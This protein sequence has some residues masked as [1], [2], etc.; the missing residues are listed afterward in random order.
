VIVRD[1]G[2]GI[3][4][5]HLARIF[6]PYFTTKQSGSG[7]G[8][9]TAYAVIQKHGGHIG[10]VSELGHGAIFTLYLPASAT[11]PQAAMAPPAAASAPAARRA[12]VLVMDDEPS[13]CAIVARM[14]KSSGC[15]VVAAADGDEAIAQYQ[16]A[17]AAGTP[18]DVVIMDL[19]IPGG[20][21]GEDAVKQLL[22]LDPHARVIVSSGYAD[23][24]VMAHYADYG[25]KGIAAKPYTLNELR[26]VLQQ[27]LQ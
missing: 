17:Q 2:S 9:A 1:E 23:D 10:V 13:I 27:V 22:A 14:L 19:T 11:P 25:F 12:R 3:D 24:P 20:M 4:P 8:L 16:Q 26:A 21:G 5:K 6:D 7:L 15:T 18:F